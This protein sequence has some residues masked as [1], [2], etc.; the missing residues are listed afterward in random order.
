M[1]KWT[2][3]DEKFYREL[4][5]R[6]ETVMDYRHSK[7]LGAMAGLRVMSVDDFQDVLDYLKENA[8]AV[9][10]ALQP[11]DTLLREESDETPG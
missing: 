4:A 1:E 11:Y 5:K 8:A 6:R 10:E 3:K 2:A 7:L 9:I